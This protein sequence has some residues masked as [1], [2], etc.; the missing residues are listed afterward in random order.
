MSKVS[1]LKTRDVSSEARLGKEWAHAV[2]DADADA[3]EEADGFAELAMVVGVI[4][5]VTEKD[6]VPVVTIDTLRDTVPE[7]VALLCLVE[8]TV[9]DDTAL[10]CVLETTVLTVEDGVAYGARFKSGVAVGQS[11]HGLTSFAP[12]TWPAYIGGMV[13]PLLM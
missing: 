1:R 6:P 12:R 2:A 8:M 13:M 3:L 4:D 10:A 7:A 9:E 5:R 11:V